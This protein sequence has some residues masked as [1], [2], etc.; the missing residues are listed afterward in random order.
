[1]L[2]SGALISFFDAPHGLDKESR[3]P[4]KKK[5]IGE[6][7]VVGEPGSCRHSAL[8]VAALLEIPPSQCN[9]I[10]RILFK[11]PVVLALAADA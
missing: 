6:W 8:A 4:D 5:Q 3:T 7:E 9:R 1:M 11:N 2:D 10:R